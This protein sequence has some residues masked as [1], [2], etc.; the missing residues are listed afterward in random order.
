MHF[1]RRVSVSSGAAASG[2]ICVS[3]SNGI[4][5][6]YMMRASARHSMSSCAKKRGTGGRDGTIQHSPLRWAASIALHCVDTTDRTQRQSLSPL[7]G[8][9]ADAIGI[10]DEDYF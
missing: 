1:I 4:S 2:H 6:V 3:I 9:A 8:G 5:P 7:I 10:E